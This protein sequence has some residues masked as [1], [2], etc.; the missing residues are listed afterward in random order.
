MSHRKRYVKQC[1]GR[2]PS[3]VGHKIDCDS[4]AYNYLG[5]GLWR[6]SNALMCGYT[7]KTGDP[8]ISPNFDKN[9][10]AAR[11]MRYREG[12]VSKID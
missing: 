8:L 9:T 3:A 12:K 6:C 10:I 1:P 4:H 2:V 11:A 5:N 7:V